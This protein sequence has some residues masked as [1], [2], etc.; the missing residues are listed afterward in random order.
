VNGVSN[1][2]PSDDD[3]LLAELGAAMRAARELPDAY[4]RAGKWSYA[5]FD[6]DSELAHLVSDS[7]SWDA[8]E[9]AAAGLRSGP[10]VLRSLGFRSRGLA[11]ELDVHAV[12][13]HGQVTPSDSG[14][15]GS[16]TSDPGTVS[17]R[18]GDAPDLRFPIDQHGWFTIRPVPPSPFRLSIQLAGGGAAVTEWIQ[19]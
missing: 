12:A 9:L 1:G 6:L 4:L 18:R 15:P 8:D 10:S 3:E 5:L 7:A 14:T 2:L 11:I 16:G 19:L 13:L 17:L